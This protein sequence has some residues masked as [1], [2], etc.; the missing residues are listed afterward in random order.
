[1]QAIEGDKLELFYLFAIMTGMRR[2]EILGLTWGKIDLA[3]R[4]AEVSASL[5]PKRELSHDVKTSSS[6]RTL[7][8]PVVLVERLRTIERPEGFVF[9]TSVGTP[10]RPDNVS[11]YMKALCKRAGVPAIPFHGLR[12]LHASHLIESGVDLK[13]VQ[14]QLGHADPR[15]TLGIYAHT[16]ENGQQRAAEATEERFKNLTKSSSR[17]SIETPDN[18]E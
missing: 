15:M 14:S 18:Q 3:N 16:M 17:S 11:K 12:H 13:T 9:L 2:G 4:T 10:Y 7:M 6:Y 8:L 5:N 1:L